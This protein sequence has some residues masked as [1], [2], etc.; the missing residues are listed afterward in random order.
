MEIKEIKG[1]PH[2]FVSSCGKV[3]SDKSGKRKEMSQ[4]RSASGKG[5]YM[6]DLFQDNKKHKKLVHRLVGLVFIE[7]SES[8]PEINH[9]DNNI[10]NNHIENLEWVTRRQNLKQSYLTMS[11]TRNF[12]ECSLYC[13]ELLIKEF[14]CIQDAAKYAEMHYKVSKSSMIKYLKCKNISIVKNV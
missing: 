4:Y 14:N 5:Y 12:A 3:F 1:Y 13:E 10:L 11:P 9:K 6:I 7:N 8:L 2:Y